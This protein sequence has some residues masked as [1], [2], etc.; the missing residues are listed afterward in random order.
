MST[1]RTL[2]VR[3]NDWTLVRSSNR[4][5]H[6]TLRLIVATVSAADREVQILSQS[7][8]STYAH[9]RGVSIY[10]SF[11]NNDLAFLILLNSSKQNGYG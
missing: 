5:D 3:A 6:A 1:Q 9:P 8:D 7:Y 10:K 4:I 2:Q 11:A